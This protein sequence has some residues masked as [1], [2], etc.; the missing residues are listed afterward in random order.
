MGYTADNPV[1]VSTNMDDYVNRRNE[2]LKAQPIEDVP[3]SQ[4][5]YTQDRINEEEVAKLGAKM[6]GE[7]PSTFGGTSVGGQ[8]VG[9]E[10]SPTWDW[11]KGAVFALKNGD[12]YY[13]LN[14]H[15][16]VVAGAEYA[17]RDT[18]PAHVL[19]VTGS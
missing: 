12:D 19:D 13:I 14:G 1:S 10:S 11:L 3:M 17:G 6:T 18:F 15:H 7:V 5:I 4:M 8:M 2:L 16:R 9:A